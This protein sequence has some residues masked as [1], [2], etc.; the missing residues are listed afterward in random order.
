MLDLRAWFNHIIDNHGHWVW[1]RRTDKRRRCACFDVSSQSKHPKCRICS[2]DGFLFD[3]E[4]HLSF[5]RSTLAIRPSATAE[6]VAQPGIID[7]SG[8]VYYFNHLINPHHFDE[9]LEKSDNNEILEMWNIERV[10]TK[11]EK[12]GRVEYYRCVC[13]KLSFGK[14]VQ[15]LLVQRG[16]LEG[17]R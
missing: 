5:N 3:E 14:D 10:E 12:Y 15:A 8:E 2:E 1:L 4:K 6:V 13:S 7:I 17:N 16:Q 9:I 11:R